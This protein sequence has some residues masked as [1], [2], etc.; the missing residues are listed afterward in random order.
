T[1]RYYEKI[2]LL[3]SPTRTE[4]HQRRYDR[5]A[6]ARLA[7]I[8]HSRE[9]GFDLEAIRTLLALQDDSDQPCASADAIAKARLGE[10]DKRIASLKALRAE[11]QHM[12]DE[13]ARG[14]V[15]ECRVIETL[16]DSGHDHG[17]LAGL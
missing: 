5:S 16:A 11:L 15:A 2:G 9:L 4:G 1:I 13:C 10:V 6:L 7:F 17:R 12:V 14:R 8:R 3:P